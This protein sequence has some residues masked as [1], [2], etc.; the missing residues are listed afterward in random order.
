MRHADIETLDARRAWWVPAVTAPSRDWPGAPGCRRGA[1]FLIDEA[2]CRPARD[3]GGAPSSSGRRDGRPTIPCFQSRGACLE[4]I[5]A[6]RAVLART[7]PQAV[8]APANLARWL[9]GLA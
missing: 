7:A 6:H 8:V 2:S 4:W 9:L 3:N 5:M 1:R